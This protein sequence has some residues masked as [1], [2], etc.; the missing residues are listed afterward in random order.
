MA[1][2]SLR[3]D[4]QIYSAGIDFLISILQPL[5]EFDRIL[6]DVPCS[7]DGTTRKNP[8]VWRKWKLHDACGLHPLQLRI[9]M[10]G[11]KL[12]AVGGLMVYSTCSLNPIEDEAVVAEVYRRAKGALELVDLSSKLPELH[13]RPGKHSWIVQDDAR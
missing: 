6:A 5:V 8:E 12:L 3:P 2:K 1:V 13:S 4:R 9:A 11:V 10:R 7:G